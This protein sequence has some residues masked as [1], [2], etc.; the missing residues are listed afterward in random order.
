MVYQLRMDSLSDRNNKSGK[1][2][3]YMQISEQLSRDISAGIL[4]EGQRLPAERQMAKDY[5][6]TVRTLRKSLARLTETGL[7]MRKQGSGNYI[8]K[9]ENADSIYSFFRLERLQGGGLPSAR[10]VRVDSLK[11]PADLPNFGG[12]SFAHRFRRQRFLDGL[13]VAA[14]EIWLDRAC[15]AKVNAAQVSQSLYKYYKDRLDVWIVRVE[16]WVGLSEVPQWADGLLAKAPGIRCGYIERYGWSQ[17]NKKV[18]YSR[19]WYDAD[20]ARYV[21]RLK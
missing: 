7:L 20:A 13:P 18:E 5:N 11:K 12:S 2:P 1:L 9:N 6:V 10:M 3:V 4:A 14:E 8:Q 15:A 16:D 17:D 19:T 21:S